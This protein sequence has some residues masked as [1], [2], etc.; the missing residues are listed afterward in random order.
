MALFIG[1]NRNGT[2][3]SIQTWTESSEQWNILGNR[4]NGKYG[5]KPAENQS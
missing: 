1:G 5:E 3:S 4:R 2:K